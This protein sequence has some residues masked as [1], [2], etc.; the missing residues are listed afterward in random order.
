MKNQENRLP[1]GATATLLVSEDTEFL[2]GRLL[3]SVHPTRQVP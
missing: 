1:K 2:T 3:E